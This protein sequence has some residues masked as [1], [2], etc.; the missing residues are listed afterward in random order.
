MRFEQVQG[1]HVAGVSARTTNAREM[2]A[3]GVIPKLWIGAIDVRDKSLHGLDAA[4]IALY[5]EYENDEHGAY[6]FVLGAKADPAWDIPDGLVM[7]AVPA[8]K[9]AVFTCERGPVQKVVVETWQRIWSELPAAKNL[10]SYIAD[11]EVYDQRA[12]DPADAVVDIY[13]GVK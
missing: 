5:T 10:R 12:A 7:K 2:T 4:M 11:F 3:E 8:G 6:T 1:F 13:V 9:Y